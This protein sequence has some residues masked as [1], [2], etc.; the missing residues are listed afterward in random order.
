MTLNAYIS[1]FFQSFST[2][3]TSNLFKAFTAYDPIIDEALA[4]LSFTNLEKLL[5]VVDY[6]AKEVSKNK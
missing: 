6:R 1:L 5:T 4:Q 3:T 2:I